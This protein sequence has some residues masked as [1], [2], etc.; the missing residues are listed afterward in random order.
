MAVKISVSTLK[1]QV[2]EGMKRKALAEYY[3]IPEL[4]MAKV[5]KQAG[6]KI[7]KF[8]APAFELVDDEPKC[9]ANESDG[10]TDVDKSDKVEDFQPVKD[11]IES[12][13]TGSGLLAEDVKEEIKEEVKEEVKEEEIPS[14][15]A[16][17]ED[18]IVVGEE[19]KSTEESEEDV[20]LEELIK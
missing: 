18:E 13:I 17:F 16:P 19:S 10:W 6:L 3:G 7:R 14:I 11:V 2:E 9:D 8:H 4:Q 5:L 1:K 12:E 20:T 15:F